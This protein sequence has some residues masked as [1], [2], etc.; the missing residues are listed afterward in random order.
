MKEEVSKLK[1]AAKR[2]KR[3]YKEEDLIWWWHFHRDILYNREVSFG[4]K[5]GEKWEREVREKERR[6]KRDREEREK[7]DRE[8]REREERIRR[9]KNNSGRLVH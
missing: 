7:R 5:T 8:E 1:Q 6:E 3:I 9:M 2:W 4:T